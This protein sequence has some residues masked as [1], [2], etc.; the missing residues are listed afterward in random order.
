MAFFQNPFTPYG[1]NDR[2][3]FKP[4]SLD[5]KDNG[6]LSSLSDAK[7]ENFQWN[8]DRFM[9]VAGH[10]TEQ[11]R[12]NNYFSGQDKDTLNTLITIQISKIIES[13]DVI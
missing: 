11:K 1:S 12:Y 6:I 8:F 2:K 13:T 10:Y 4:N 9:V 7:S 3:I 5:T